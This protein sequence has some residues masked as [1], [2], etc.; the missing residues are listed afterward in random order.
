MTD[1]DERPRVPEDLPVPRRRLGSWRLVRSYREAADRPSDPHAHTH[2]APPV[3]QDDE[4]PPLQ[5]TPRRERLVSRFVGALFALAVVSSLTF[6]VCYFVIPPT[7]RIG[8]DLNTALGAS[9]GTT[10]AALA[11]GL[12]VMGKSFA[13]AVHSEQE[14]EPHHSEPDDESA[15]EEIIVG[16]ASEIGLA[17]RRFVRRGLIAALGLLPV[18]FVIGLRDVGPLPRDRMFR[19]AWTRG[20]RLVDPDTLTPFKLGDLEIGSMAT[21]MPE[22]HTEATLPVNA[23]SAVVLIHLPPGVNRPLPGRADWAVGDIVAYS[24]IC[25]HAGCPVGLY[26]QQSHRLLCPCHQSTFD[27]PN[28]CKAIFGPAARALPQLPIY[29]D[30]DGYLRARRPFNQPLG[31]SFW[32]RA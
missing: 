19:N 32:E 21:A 30:R 31:P 28:G 14:R 8:L 7:W 18:P 25:T 17:Q 22:N 12:I 3:A 10:M 6:S 15:A 5:R 4:L 9:L 1:G 26:E 29:A 27:V 13:P 11:V 24:K 16:G 2:E 23:E 20:V